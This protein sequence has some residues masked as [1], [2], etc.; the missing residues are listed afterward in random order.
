MGGGDYNK[1]AGCRDALSMCG[2]SFNFRAIKIYDINIENHYVN[3]KITEV[4]TEVLLPFR[5]D[6]V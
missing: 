6:W 4:I 1:T 2:C 3:V 5:F